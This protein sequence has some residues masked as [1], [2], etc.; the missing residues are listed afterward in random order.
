MELL[1]QTRL[2]RY[3]AHSLHELRSQ[4]ETAEVIVPDSCPDVARAAYACAS[5][6]VRGKECRTG[7]ILIS[8]GIR[9]SA[10][11]VPEDASGARTLEAYMP[12]TMRIEHPSVTERTQVFLNAFVRQVDAR[13]VNSRKILFR[14]DLVCAADGYEP[15]EETLYTLQNAPAGLELKKQTYPVTLPAETAE[16][17]F[18]I[19]EELELPQGKVFAA[20]VCAYQTWPEITDSKVVGN[21]AVFKG[22]LCFRLLYLSGDGSVNTWEQQIPFSQYSELTRDY[23]EAPLCVSILVTA[24]ELELR[25]DSDGRQMTLRVGLTAQ[26]LVSCTEEMEL[27]EDAY[28]VNG[29]LELEWKQYD[30]DC[31]LDRQ[32]LRDDLRAGVECDA[33]SIIDCMVYPDAPYLERTDD[34]LRIQAPVQIKLLYL[35]SNGELQGASDKAEA[36]CQTALCENAKCIAS[37]SSCGASAQITPDGAQ[38]RAEIAFDL[39]CS[40]VQDLHTLCGGT[41]TEAAAKDPERPSVVLRRCRMRESVWDVAKQYGTAVQAVMDA[42][43]IQGDMAEEGQMLLIPM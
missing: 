11:C 37:A 8:G 13:L 12:F 6:I 16:K 14:V 10:L 4:E 17:S 26:C 1:F 41:L 31:R 40:A 7:S 36:G 29:T 30:L 25:A 18:S 35:D 42:N 38:V 9:A 23:E 19:S 20:S 43:A 5:V 21:K 39:C 33:S 32:T 28:A 22:N 15:K 24:A 3:L 27:I 34:G 2:M